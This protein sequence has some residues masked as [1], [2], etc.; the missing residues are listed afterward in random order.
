MKN[1]EV[2]LWHKGKLRKLSPASGE[3]FPKGYLLVLEERGEQDFPQTYKRK[4]TEKQTL[5]ITEK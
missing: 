4:V 5:C 3:A 2:K 1:Y